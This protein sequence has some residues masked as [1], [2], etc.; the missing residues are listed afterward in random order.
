MQASQS[1]FLPSDSFKCV[2]ANIFAHYL[3]I[4][5]ICDI[6]S[7]HNEAIFYEM[8]CRD[9][10]CERSEQQSI[11]LQMQVNSPVWRMEGKR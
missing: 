9:V 5:S 11:V 10:G 1:N 4:H 6:L 7:R 2:S 8:S 3:K